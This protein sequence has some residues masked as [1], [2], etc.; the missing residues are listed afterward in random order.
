MFSVAFVGFFVCNMGKMIYHDQGDLHDLS[1]LVYRL[2]SYCINSR[3]F[4]FI[5]FI[6]LFII[7]MFCHHFAVDLNNTYIVEDAYVKAYDGH[8]CR[9]EHTNF[10]K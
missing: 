3:L 5:L 4:L 2:K 9:F 10:R 1:T 8:V 6:E 7:L